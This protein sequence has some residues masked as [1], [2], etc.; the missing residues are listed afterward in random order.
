[1]G[2]VARVARP[3]DVDASS[4]VHGD[5]EWSFRATPAEV[6][7]VKARGGPR[8][9]RIEFGHEAIAA[10]RVAELVCARRN[11]QITARAT[12]GVR[13]EARYIGV[14]HAVDGHSVAVLAVARR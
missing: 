13:R 9:V 8:R 1:H 7:G 12:I 2:Q 10:A 3:G 14:I 11:W 4:T 6:G 5:T